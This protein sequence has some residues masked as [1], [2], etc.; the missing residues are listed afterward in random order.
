MVMV[1]IKLLSGFVPDSESLREVGNQ[2]FMLSLCAGDFQ[3][4]FY[5]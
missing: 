3:G 5:C 2:S 4:V 1:D